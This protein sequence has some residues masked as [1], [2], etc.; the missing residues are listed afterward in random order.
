MISLPTKP[1]LVQKGNNRAKFK[2]EG[3]YPGYGI[4]VGNS[5]RRVLL[6]SLPGAAITKVKIKGVAHEF[7]TIPGVLEDVLQIL[8]NLKQARLRMEGGQPLPITLKIK[9]LEKGKKERNIKGSDIKCPSQLEVVNKDLHLAT[10]TSSKGE[11]NM[12]ME[13][14]KG[15]GYLSVGQRKKEKVE[16]GTIILDAFFTPVRRVNFEVENMIVGKRTDYNRLF[17]DIK[18]DGTIKPEDALYQALKILVDHFKIWLEELEK[19]PKKS[20][21]KTT[22]KT[23][24]KAIKKTV[25]ESLTKKKKK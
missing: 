18:T 16:I 20:V 7:S 13:V 3:L 5:L 19:S 23:T 8:L 4:T 14:E 21:K 12:E 9:G 6:S 10:I 24:K 22:K 2:I 25:K 11:L 17:L 15:L 1:K